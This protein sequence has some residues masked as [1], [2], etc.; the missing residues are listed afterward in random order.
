MAVT[1]NMMGVHKVM[2]VEV[3]WEVRI[4]LEHVED[5]RSALWVSIWLGLGIFLEHVA[6]LDCVV[7]Y[8]GLLL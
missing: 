6:A 2:A 5:D 3:Q 1:V 7:R 4:E 8:P